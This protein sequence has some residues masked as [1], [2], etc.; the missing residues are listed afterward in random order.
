MYAGLFPRGYLEVVYEDPLLTLWREGE[1]SWGA[2]LMN[3]VVLCFDS[4]VSGL[5]L[6]ALPR[7]CP[8]GARAILINVNLSLQ[9]V[10]CFGFYCEGNTVFE[11]VVIRNDFDFLVVSDK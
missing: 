9:A 5:I 10:P 11:S 8:D 1:K 2:V 3:R 6:A 7:F 4:P